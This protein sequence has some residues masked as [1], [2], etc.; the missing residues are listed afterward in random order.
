MKIN[1]NTV[2]KVLLKKYL[3]IIIN[4]KEVFQPETITNLIIRTYKK[5]NLEQDYIKMQKKEGKNI[6][7]SNQIKIL[8]VYH[9]NKK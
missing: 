1:I 9:K 7:Q 4:C 6:R 8:E 3:Q 5:Q 2:Q